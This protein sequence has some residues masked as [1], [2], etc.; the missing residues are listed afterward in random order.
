M[1]LLDLTSDELL[2]TTRAVRKRLDLTRFVEPAVIEQCVEIALQAPI[3]PIIKVH[4]VIVTDPAQREALAALYRKG[5]DQVVQ[6]RDQAL[7][8][9]GA[10]KPTLIRILDSAQYLYDHL[11]EVPVH[12]IPC[13]EGRTDN[14]SVVEQAGTWGSILPATWNF[15]LAARSRSLG[16]VWT[17]NHLLFER[18]AADVLGIPYEQVMQVALIPVAYTLGTEFRVAKRPPL[19]SVL[20]RDRW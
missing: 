15:M 7:A 3:P 4:F 14:T 18:E 11:H 17:G 20:H 2:T 1:P 10:E 9:A 13:I 12:V 19:T 16:T 6:M 5:M 8:A